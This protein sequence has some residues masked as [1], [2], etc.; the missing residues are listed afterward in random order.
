MSDKKLGI[1]VGGGPAPGINAVIGA[2]TIAAIN[3]GFEVIGFYNGFHNLVSDAFQAETHARRL[4]IP[5]V[6]RI[7]F[8]GGSMLR[9]SRTNLIDKA[10]LKNDSKVAPDPVKIGNVLKNLNDLGVNHMLTIGGDD[11][12][13]S[14][15]LISDA[16]D[17]KIRV[18]HCPKTIDNDLPLPHG[19]P[20]LGFT[21]AVHYGAQLIKNLMRDSQTTGRWYFVA[22]MGRSAGWLGQRIAQAA[23]STVCVIPEEFAERSTVANICDVLEGSM[24]KRR[25]LGRPDGVAVVAEGVAYQLGDVAEMEALTGKPV[26][27]D[28]AGHPRLAEFPLI[29]VLK[30]EMNRRFTERGDKV[31]IV[32]HTL[33][34]E[35]RCADPVPFD[36][37]Y[38]RSL[39]WGAVQVL[40]DHSQT[41]SKMI[42]I[43][44][45]NVTPVPFS[46]LINP[47]TNRTT[48][49]QVDIDSDNYRVA[50]AYQIRL[51]QSDLEDGDTLA[52]LAREAKLEPQAFADR[53]RRAATRLHD[54][55]ADMLKG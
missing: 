43:V 32:S 36:M 6:A 14:A 27:L 45:D 54:M 29:E 38:C 44:N 7:H 20:T 30:Q 49:R 4:L 52:R 50:R 39:G 48:V 3:Q 12:S 24:L 23:G 34:Y 11:T 15:R 13:L 37:R 47:E 8:E 18:V 9:T 19:V 1:V 21:T 16:S 5:D 42:T 33:G 46:E 25:V 26:P 40:D 51:E 31:T 35:L 41:A 55:P 22:A 10:K 17:G 2:A 28:E 53:Y